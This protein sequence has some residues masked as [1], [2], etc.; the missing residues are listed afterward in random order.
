MC[1]RTADPFASVA[2]VENCS[3]ED[4]VR[5]TAF[6]TAEPDTF[7]SIPACVYVGKKTVGGFLASDEDG[8][9]FIV[10]KTGVNAMLIKPLDSST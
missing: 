3:C 6:A 10:V 1:F 4:G 8:W 9:R 2:K 5:R 7:F